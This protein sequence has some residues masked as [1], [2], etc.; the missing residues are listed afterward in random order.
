[1]GGHLKPNLHP[2]SYPINRT[3]GGALV[4]RQATG[5]AGLQTGLPNAELPLLLRIPEQEGLPV[6]L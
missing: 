5:R 4:V 6:S 2:Q 1:M 3:V